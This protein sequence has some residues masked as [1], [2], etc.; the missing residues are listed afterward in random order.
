MKAI[1][2]KILMGSSGACSISTR[3]KRL[4][5]KNLSMPSERN[6]MRRK[7][8]CGESLH[9]YP[10][11]APEHRKSQ[12]DDPVKVVQAMED[13]EYEGLTGPEKFRACDHQ[14]VKPYYTLQCKAPR[15]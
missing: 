8:S 4:E 14:A 13:F 7:L 11:A 5:I 9:Q 6:S 2:P 15:P 10:G 1:G 12:N 3:S